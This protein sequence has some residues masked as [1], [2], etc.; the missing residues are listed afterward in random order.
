MTLGVMQWVLL[1][2][3]CLNVA[4]G[5]Y[6]VATNRLPRFPLLPRD[7]EPRRHGWGQL[8][9]SVFVATIALAPTTMEWPYGLSIAVF[10]LGLGALFAGLWIMC[11]GKQNQRP[12]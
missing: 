7:I 11:S 8:M 5:I 9:V 6:S 3:G 12:F 1:G 2:V 10:T 4:L